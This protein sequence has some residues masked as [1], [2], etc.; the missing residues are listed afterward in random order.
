M[1]YYNFTDP[2]Q[3]ALLWIADGGHPLIQIK[4]YAEIDGLDG[5][6]WNLDLTWKSRAIYYIHSGTGGD[7]VERCESREAVADFEQELAGLTGNESR[8]VVENLASSCRWIKEAK[9]PAAKRVV[10]YL[11]GDDTSWSFQRKYKIS[12]PLSL[13]DEVEMAKEI[14]K[15]AQRQGSAIEC[16]FNFKHPQAIHVLR[17]F[18][19]LEVYGS[20]M[21]G[22]NHA[23]AC[24]G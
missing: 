22:V 6:A 5:P 1:T 23:T 3:N 19:P 13:H 16:A 24:E 21:G 11:S 17:K 8:F 2:S 9:K 14:V 12:S 10:Y 15:H 4:R 18:Q 20:D 7:P